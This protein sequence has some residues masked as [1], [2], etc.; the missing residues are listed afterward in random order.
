MPKKTGIIF[1]TM[2]AVL[3][4]SAL[5]LFLYNGYEQQRA[6]QQA[7]LLLHDIQSAMTEQGEPKQE[8]EEPGDTNQSGQSAP[9]KDRPDIP[10]ATEETA[11]LSAQMPEVIIEGYGYI[12]YLSLPTLDL[13]LPVMSQ[14]DYNRLKIAPCRHFGSSRTDDLVIA[15][16]NYKTHFGRLGLLKIGDPVSF[17]DME[18]IVNQYTVVKLVTV[19]PEDVDAVLNS[20]HDLVLYTCTSGRAKRVVAFCDRITDS[21]D[22]GERN[23]EG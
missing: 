2:G 5:L 19:L 9:Q 16:H 17:T 4:L 23:G 21:A 13:E 11:S 18:G 1:A 10:D 22:G 20:E 6:G 8:T 15:A 14:W 3:I 7:E 12:G